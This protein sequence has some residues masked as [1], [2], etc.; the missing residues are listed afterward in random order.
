MKWG[1][2]VAGDVMEYAQLPLTGVND[3]QKGAK[4]GAPLVGPTETAW[5]WMYSV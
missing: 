1:N 5:H 3:H 4:K 2:P